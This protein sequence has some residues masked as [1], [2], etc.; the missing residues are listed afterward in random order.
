MRIGLPFVF[1]VDPCS[2]E[3]VAGSF[4]VFHGNVLGSEDAE[5]QLVVL[6]GLWLHVPDL[7]LVTLLEHVKPAEHCAL[8]Q[9]RTGM[10]EL[11]VLYW[12]VLD[13]SPFR[14]EEAIV[15]VN[16]GPPDKLVSKEVIVVP[17]LD[18]QRR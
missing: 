7:L 5:T 10:V 1:F 18:V 17:R 14:R 13:G 9:A 11:S 12:L 15:K 2:D 3:D 6:L 4:E 8:G 16:R